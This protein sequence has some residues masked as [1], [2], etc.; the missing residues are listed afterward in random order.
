MTQFVIEPI[1]FIRTCFPEKFG[2]PRQAL[3]APAATGVLELLPPYNDPNTVSGLESASHLW[4]TFVF[5][6]HL[7]HDWKSKVRPPRLGGNQKTGVFATRSPF[8][9]NFLG[10]SAVKLDSIECQNYRLR[11]HLSG[12]DL[13][14]K[15]PI[16]D[17]KPYVPYADCISGASN[18]LA[19]VPPAYIPVVFTDNAIGFIEN[20]SDKQYVKQLIEQVLQQDPRPAYQVLD[21]ER[22][23]K[24]ALL[25]LDIEWRCCYRENVTVIEVIR[26]ADKETR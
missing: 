26:L 2:I 18:T 10:L 21:D 14:D 11:L 4:L 6:Q 15:T 9:P 20:R 23:Y 22:V 5:H 7:H 19:S 8:R 24:M 1:G 12:V 16:V 13:L 3:L 17:I 25:T